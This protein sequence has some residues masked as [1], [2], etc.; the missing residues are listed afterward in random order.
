MYSLDYMPGNDFLASPVEV[1]ADLSSGNTLVLERGECDD[2]LSRGENLRLPSPRGRLR[3]DPP[4][5]S[6]DY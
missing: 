5:T 2:V 4:L 3:T 6:L 1:V